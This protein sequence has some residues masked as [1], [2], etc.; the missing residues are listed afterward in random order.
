[1]AKAGEIAD[2]LEGEAPADATKVRMGPD[3]VDFLSDR[4][5]YLATTSKPPIASW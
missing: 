3:S 1:M 4:H 5:P 2:A